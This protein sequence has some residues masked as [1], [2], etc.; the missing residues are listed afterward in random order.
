MTESFPHSVMEFV[1]DHGDSSCLIVSVRSV[2]VVVVVVVVVI[3]AI[4]FSI[5]YKY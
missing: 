1:P 3:T 5:V 4:K 2:V